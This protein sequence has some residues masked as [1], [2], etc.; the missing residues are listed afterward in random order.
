M[1]VIAIFLQA[2]DD[3]RIVAHTLLS[4]LDDHSSRTGLRAFQQ[5][6]FGQDKP[7]LENQVPRRLP[8]DPAAETSVRADKTAVAYRRWLGARRVGYGVIPAPAP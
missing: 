3:E 5:I 2:L 7:I 8:L 4:M 1:D 6:I